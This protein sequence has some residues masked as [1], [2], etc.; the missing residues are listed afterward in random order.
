M[1]NIL[2]YALPISFALV[3]LVL[4]V[5]RSKLKNQIKKASSKAI[6]LEDKAKE[7]DKRENSLLAELSSIKTE[8]DKA[9]NDLI[10]FQKIR[11]IE[12]H[13][14]DLTDEQASVNQSIEELRSSY[15]FKKKVYNELAERVAIF[16]EQIELAE[17]GYYEPHFGFETSAQY[18]EK[19]EKIKSY[20]KSLIKQKAHI[21]CSANWEVS[22][23]KSEGKKFTN[24][25]I[26]LTSRAYN[27]ECDAAMEK[28]KWNNAYQMLERLDKSFADIN[29]ANETNQVQISLDYH[30]LKRDEL[31]LRHEMKEKIQQERDHEKELRAQAAEEKRLLKEIAD[32]QKEE[33]K[34]QK[35]LA[36][37]ELQAQKLSGEKLDQLNSEMEKLKQ[38][39]EE[40]HSRNERAKSMAEQTKAGFVY[41]ISNLGSFGENVYKIGMTRRL[42]PM[43]RVKEL[44]D[45]S[46]P[47]TFDVHAMIYTDNAPELE[48]DL[49]REFESTRVNMVN[50]HKE[51]FRT[52]LDAIKAAAAQRDPAAEFYET[53][54]AKEYR[55]SL[56]IRAKKE[57]QKQQDTRE[58][59]PE[60]I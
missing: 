47:F 46:V 9:E 39:L 36:K 28:V 35:L 60:A 15:S 45:A 51:F 7:A 41:V 11:D 48:K 40:A 50:Y 43:D 32:A 29:K 42:E 21:S 56:A 34:Y 24:R 2:P 10:R 18:K 30:N 4:L 59:F 37:A 49:H 6:E 12:Q 44:G 53:A 57:N 26:K 1:D 38:E 16:N 22:G 14:A 27:A 31:R 52:S 55:E 58:A 17:Y 54:E 23:S 19:L 25:I 8:L 33:D 5:S 13:I 20:Q 3:V